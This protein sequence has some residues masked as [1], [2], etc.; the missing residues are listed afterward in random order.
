MYGLLNVRIVESLI[1]YIVQLKAGGENHALER[2]S[3][4]YFIITTTT[5]S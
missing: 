2:I 3:L 1:V 5:A 4:H